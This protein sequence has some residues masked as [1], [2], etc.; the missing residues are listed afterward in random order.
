MHI[1][2]ICRSSWLSPQ[3]RITGAG[4]EELRYF[5]EVLSHADRQ[6]VFADFECPA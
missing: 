3:R 6:L 5:M 1:L 2:R 4:L